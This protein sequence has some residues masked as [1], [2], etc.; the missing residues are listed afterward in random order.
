MGPVSPEPK[1]SSLS[2][3]AK[4]T[5]PPEGF[6]LLNYCQIPAKSLK[7]S[8]C[9]C[10]FS[11]K[12]PMVSHHLHL[13]QILLQCSCWLLEGP[14]WCCYNHHRDP[15]CFVITGLLLNQMSSTSAAGIPPCLVTL[16]SRG[17]PSSSLPASSK[18]SR[19]VSS[20]LPLPT[21]P[22]E[23]LHLRCCWHPAW[24]AESS[25][26]S[27]AARCQQGLLRG[28][29]MSF[30]VVDLQPSHQSVPSTST[31]LWPDNRGSLLVVVAFYQAS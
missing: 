27:I 19:G 14:L 22:P 2:P 7:G 12:P 21:K 28:P 20:P 3:Q 9:C 1:S 17:L 31:N 23:G 13:H 24:H 29:V 30:A 15:T 26:S 18:A 5:K 10:Q 8:C 6:C 11:D 25:I 16:S 4:E